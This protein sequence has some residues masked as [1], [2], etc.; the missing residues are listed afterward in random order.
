[1]KKTPA[2][3]ALLFANLGIF[4]GTAALLPTKG[5]W[6]SSGPI[7]YFINSR[8]RWDVAWGVLVACLLVSIGILLWI[9]ARGGFEK[10]ASGTGA[11]E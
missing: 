7:S 4:V 3:L 10:E 6:G 9:Q 11:D 1:M 8:A 5:S 2:I